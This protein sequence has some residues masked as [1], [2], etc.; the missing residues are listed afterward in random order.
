MAKVDELVARRSGFA[1]FINAHCLNVAWSDVRYREILNRAD[2]V[3][4]DGSGV[5]LAGKMRGFP[6]PDNVNG[7]DMFPLLCAKPYRIYMLGA[8]PGVA[9]KA[10][11]NAKKRFPA[12]CFVGASP[13]FFADEGEE[14][15]VIARI[16]ALDPD[17]L[18]V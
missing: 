15:A 8:S 2:A 16:N 11:E 14:R 13:G 17:L 1:A 6:V 4:P 18:L 3:W 12:A 10:M 5:R 7:T 9:D